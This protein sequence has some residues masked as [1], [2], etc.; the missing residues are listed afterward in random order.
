MSVLI[1]ADGSDQVNEF[2]QTLF[3]QFRVGIDFRQN[4]FLTK[5]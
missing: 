2:A 3:I 5:H 1:K 4:A